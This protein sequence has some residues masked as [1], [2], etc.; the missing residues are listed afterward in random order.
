[1]R[2]SFGLQVME[3]CIECNLHGKKFFCDLPQ[4]VLQELNSIKF[5]NI[6]SKGAMLFVEGQ[7]AR[8][9]F[10]LCSGRVKLISTSSDGHTMMRAVGAGEVLGLSATISNKPYE[11]TAE[12]LEPCQ[13]NFIRAQDF[14]RF[15]H[16]HVDVCMRAAQH[17]SNDYQTANEQVR[18]LG[19]S[20]STT[21]KLAR[22]MLLWCEESGKETEQGIRIKLGLT[23]EEMAQMIG[24]SR[25]T[26]TRLLGELRHKDIIQLKGSTL[27]ISNKGGLQALVG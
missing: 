10:V 15:L 11:V 23:H 21:E 3:N 24:A 5:S 1:M 2:R 26:V 14:M 20:G 18:S 22:L 9:V 6:Y 16:D 7:S 4:E 25:E 13:A 27:I 8:G 19:L 17:L 12:V